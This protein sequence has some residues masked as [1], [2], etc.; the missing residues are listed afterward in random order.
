MK[1]ETKLDVFNNESHRE[2][3]RFFH[4][5]NF[6]ETNFCNYLKGQ[7]SNTGKGRILLR[8]TWEYRFSQVYR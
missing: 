3:S 2:K 1:K 4:Q 8:E 6:L 7:D 5:M